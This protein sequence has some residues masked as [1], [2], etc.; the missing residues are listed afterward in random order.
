MAKG[1]KIIVTA[2]PKGTFGGGYISGTPKPGTCVTIKA[3]TAPIGGRH[4]WEAFSPASGAMAMFAILLED[5]NGN[6]GV[7]S[8]AAYTGGPPAPGDAYVT[9]AYVPLYFP[10]A[11]EDFNLI[12]H[13]VSGTGDDIAIGSLFGIE[14]ATGKLIANSAY[15]NPCFT[16]LETVTD[17]TADFML[18]VKFGP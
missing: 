17:P 9:G 18:W 12:F 15:A 10:V 11:G 8:A 7:G 3:A 2:N 1:N 16:A 4:T 13:D 6:L 5:L 14:T